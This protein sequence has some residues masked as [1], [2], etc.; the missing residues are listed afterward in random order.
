M[1]C[2][3]LHRSGHGQSRSFRPP[4]SQH[5]QIA[6]AAS[7]AHC[8]LGCRG[9]KPVAGDMLGWWYNLQVEPPMSA[10]AKTEHFSRKT[11]QFRASS[12]AAH[13]SATTPGS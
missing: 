9:K 12:T 7:S 6:A 2:V 10:M 4:V 13:R 8:G 5:P 11:D 3:R 1:A